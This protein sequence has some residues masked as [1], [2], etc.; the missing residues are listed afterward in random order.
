MRITIVGTG[1]VGMVTGA[2]FAEMGNHVTCVDIDA[3]KLEQLRQGIV[4]IHE[5]GLEELIETNVP[6][7]RLTFTHRLGDCLNESDVVL[8]AV[9]TPPNEDGSADLQH[10]IAVA[11][12]IGRNLQSP[13]VIVD[14]STVPIGTA[15]RV[16]A[17]VQEQLDQR[18]LDLAFDV[19]SNPEFLKEGAAISDF[20]SPDRIVIGT[21][22]ET[23]R[24]LMRELYA[25]FSRHHDKLQFMGVRDAE[26]TKYAANAMLAARISFMNE[27]A[28][29]C[30]HYG[31]DVENVRRGIGA[32]QRIGYSFIY[33]GVGYGGSCFPKDVRAPISMA[34]EAGIETPLFQAIEARNRQQKSLLMRKIEDRFGKDLNGLTFAIWGLAFKPETDDVREAPALTMI[35]LL[36]A[37]GASI[38]AYDPAAIESM[39]AALVDTDSSRLLFVDS[40]EQAVADA[41]ALIILTEW[42]EFRQ[43][44]FARLAQELADRIIFDG[45][46][47]YEPA[48]VANFG[49]TY[50]GVGRSSDRLEA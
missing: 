29:M 50:I 6:A 11:R 12:E 26:M 38:K 16:R 46:N 37:A 33:P 7:G 22:E 36:M 47:I 17:T 1:Y 31:V 2:C 32:D 28:A 24:Q 14:K 27:I 45:R 5:P 21:L 15:D 13:T 20:M 35:E 43:P 30:E 25:P 23:S 3:R 41:N 19:V 18:G 4:P 8:I 40:A 10:V 44:D 34:K 49:L 9:G 39:K 48:R 42:K